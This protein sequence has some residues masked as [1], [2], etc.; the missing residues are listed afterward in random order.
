M[1]YIVQADLLADIPNDVLIQLTDDNK[2]G[3]V[4]A[5]VVTDA[6]TRAQSEVD[7]YLAKRYS[8][9]IAT[10]PQLV[11][12]LTATITC[13]RLFGRRG[14]GVPDDWSKRYDNAVRTL[15]DIAAG[16]IA[17]DVEPPP[18]ESSAVTA[19]EIKGPDRVFDRDKLGSF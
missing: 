14:R 13:Y 2:D 4:D 10:P 8:V 9:P 6:I 18:A 19:G 3:A 15:R 17:L 1:A 16:T 5:T 11:K 12:S 7:G